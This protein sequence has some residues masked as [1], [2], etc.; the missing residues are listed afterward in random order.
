MVRWWGGEGQG[1]VDFCF[2]FH[3]EDGEGAE[4]LVYLQQL[5]DIL[6]YHLA[7]DN[8]QSVV[9]LAF[10]LLEGAVY[11]TCQ[12]FAVAEISL[13]VSLL[14]KG[15]AVG[16]V[17]VCK[18]GCAVE[19]VAEQAVVDSLGVGVGLLDVGYVLVV[20]RQFAAYVGVDSRGRE[21]A[22]LLEFADGCFVFLD[23]L[24]HEGGGVV[25]RRQTVMVY[26]LSALHEELQHEAA[27]LA[28]VSVVGG[29]VV[30]DGDVAGALQ[31]AVE[32]VGVEGYFVVDGGEV[33]CLAYGVG[34]ERGVVDA[35][36]HVAFVAGE[37][38]EVV[39]VDVA[40]LEHAHYLYAHNGLAVEGYG[41]GADELR[42]ES[43]Q[44]GVV[45]EEVAAVG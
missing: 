12:Q 7:V 5:G 9:G 1:G 44:R 19:D 23:G 35:L 36:G 21:A 10:L 14:N 42:D 45:D 30:G 24:R 31:Q 22:H 8:L 27:H 33:V 34:Y 6:Y 2:F 3:G 37:E 13:Y 39:E 15:A 20:E 17:F 25:I 38:E 16:D 40:R 43:A 28:G 32:V 4:L 18:V 26:L 41:R 11:D 29:V